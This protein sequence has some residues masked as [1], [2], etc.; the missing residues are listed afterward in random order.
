MTFFPLGTILRLFRLARRGSRRALLFLL[1]FLGG[2]ALI[3]LGAIA[4]S[5]ILAVIGAVLVISRVRCQQTRHDLAMN[6]DNG[7]TIASPRPGPWPSNDRFVTQW[8]T[9][10]RPVRSGPDDRI[11]RSDEA[12]SDAR[13]ATHPPLRRAAFAPCATRT[14]VN[15]RRD[16]RR[17]CSRTRQR[18]VSRQAAQ[19]VQRAEPQGSSPTRALARGAR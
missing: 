2:L 7:H 11:R 17:R 15:V 14:A 19:L 12:N 18:R 13:N 6:G 1:A 16:P 3:V 10:P 9:V 4:G 8:T 5:T